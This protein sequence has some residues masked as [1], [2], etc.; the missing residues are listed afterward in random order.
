MS[1]TCREEA[2]EWKAQEKE[3]LLREKVAPFPALS[4]LMILLD[5]CQIKSYFEDMNILMKAIPKFCTINQHFKYSR[6]NCNVV[7]GNG[8]STSNNYLAFMKSV[9]EY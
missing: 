6:S 1:D 8:I 5:K 3:R 9:T 7:S 4:I 2:S